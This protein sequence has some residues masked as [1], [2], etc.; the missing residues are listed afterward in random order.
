MGVGVAQETGFGI[1]PEL[2]LYPRQGNQL[3]VGQLGGDPHRG[4]LGRPF[5]VLDQQIIDCHV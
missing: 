1:E 3:G 5:G 2:H 4:T